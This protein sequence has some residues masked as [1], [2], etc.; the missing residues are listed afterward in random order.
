MRSNRI[1]ILTIC[2]IVLAALV[3]CSLIPVFALGQYDRM[4]FDD[5]DYSKYT[6]G[7]VAQGG[8]LGD[9]LSAA[10]E[11]VA[12]NYNTWQGTYSAVF[13]FSLQPGI[14]SLGLYAI[15]PVIQIGFLIAGLG[16]FLHS[17]IRTLL[18]GKRSVW[19]IIWMISTL[20]CV[21]FPREA[22]EGFYW[23]NSAMLYT[24]FFSLLLLWIGFA[25]K[26]S[27]RKEPNGWRFW[28]GG[29]LMT[30]FTAII[31][32]ANYPTA[33]IFGVIL[34]GWV[35][36][37]A[38]KEHKLLPVTIVWLVVFIA[39]FL[40]NLLAPGNA[41]RQTEYEM[42]NPLQAVIAAILGTPI[43]MVSQ[44]FRH[45]GVLGIFALVW[46]PFCIVLLRENSRKFRLPLLA[47][48]A[49]WLILAALFT[50]PY[51]AMGFSGP[52]RL[53]NIIIFTFYLLL[54]GNIY[55]FVGWWKRRFPNAYAKVLNLMLRFKKLAPVYLAFV[56]CA[57]VLLSGVGPSIGVERE[58]PTTVRAALALLDGKSRVFA[59][60]L[61]AQIEAVFDSS[62]EK[63]EVPAI[64]EPDSLLPD[65]DLT[66]YIGVRDE[67]NTWYGKQLVLAAE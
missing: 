28:V 49:T 12:V 50:P 10:V 37:S 3:V 25:V 19:I 9:V 21:Q 38:W 17:I 59:E 40:V 22:K 57:S 15:T 61:D 20:L 11:T 55:Y 30:V 32:G 8:S 36:W 34:V 52:Y 65:G 18:N 23:F 51:Y 6:R 45:M 44:F 46:I 41:V 29:G 58:S 48:V 39:G 60:A 64:P 26:F 53:W 35:A 56:V 14:W 16:V 67:L 43:R 4:A 2:A 24:F 1:G 63:V 13:L 42:M 27:V 47:P 7:A 54:M 31:A 5:Y 66:R 62:A 33:M